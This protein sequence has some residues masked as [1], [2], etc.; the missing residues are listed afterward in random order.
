[1]G[2][3]EYVRVTYSKPESGQGG[4]VQSNRSFFSKSW[5][6]AI[7]SLVCSWTDVIGDILIAPISNLRSAQLLHV[8]SPVTEN[9][10]ALGAEVPPSLPSVRPKKGRQRVLLVQVLC[11]RRYFV[12]QSLQLSASSISSG[13]WQEQT[14]RGHAEGHEG[15]WPACY[16]CNANAPCLMCNGKWSRFL[17]LLLW[18]AWA[19]Y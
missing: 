10:V 4:N 3:S 7:V 8:A 13:P 15:T 9:A 12:L 5:L 17:L 18:P 1:M 11:P 14:P 2:E 19:K 16:I 6:M